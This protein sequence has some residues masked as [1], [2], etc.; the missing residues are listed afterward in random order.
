V[1][2]CW[3]VR[4]QAG[5]PLTRLSS[6]WGRHR[7]RNFRSLVVDAFELPRFT[8]VHSPSATRIPSNIRLFLSSK[9]CGRLLRL[10]H[11]APEPRHFIRR[12]DILEFFVYSH[13]H[14]A[15]QVTATSG[16]SSPDRQP[17]RIPASWWLQ[18]TMSTPIPNPNGSSLG[19]GIFMINKT[20]V[21]LLV[22]LL[23]T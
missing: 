13:A 14:L 6:Q 5:A 12:P 3:R 16:P 18:N 20:R 22:S 21:L 7:A 1:R 4:L 15:A 23:V 17:N 19:N 11:Y 9:V 8:A 10:R 2:H